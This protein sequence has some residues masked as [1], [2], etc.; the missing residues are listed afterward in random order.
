MEQSAQDHFTQ[1]RLEAD[2]EDDSTH[3]DGSRDSL[4]L[5]AEMRVASQPRSEPVRVRNLSTGGLMA[6]YP[7]GLHQGTT[8][9]LDIRGIGLVAGRVAWSAA[10]RIG[11]AFERGIDPQHARKPIGAASRPAPG[12]RPF[13]PRR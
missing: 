5:M 6:D 8:V 4:F 11:V 3:R 10:G 7:R 12:G 1:D 13:P 9:E 2:G